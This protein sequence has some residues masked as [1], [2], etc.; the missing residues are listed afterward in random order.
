MDAKLSLGISAVIIIFVIASSISYN[1]S[2]E[3]A[4]NN[5]NGIASNILRIGYF[6]NLNH[7]QAVIGLETGSLHPFDR[8]VTKTL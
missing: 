4:N 5:N 3:N 7:A 8:S 6:P 2:P 1:A